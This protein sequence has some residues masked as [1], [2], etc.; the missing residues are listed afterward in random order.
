LLSLSYNLKLIL[1]RGHFKDK[2]TLNHYIV[3][4][5]GHFKDKTGAKVDY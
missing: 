2:T 4:K 3:L 5:R 1:K